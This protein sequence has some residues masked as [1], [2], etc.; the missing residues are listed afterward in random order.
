MLHVV[1]HAFRR[2]NVDVRRR[3]WMGYHWHDFH[4][5]DRFQSHR[6]LERSVRTSGMFLAA[7]G[8]AWQAFPAATDD[9]SVAD[10]STVDFHHRDWLFLALW[11]RARE[12]GS[13]RAFSWS[14]SQML[15]TPIFDAQSGA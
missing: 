5:N 6:L 13:S 3:D 2:G 7:F 10:S 11:R 4:H 8:E 12:Y 14:S 15:R 1:W 9:F